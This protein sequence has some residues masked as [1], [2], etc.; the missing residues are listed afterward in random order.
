MVG[1]DILG[2]VMVQTIET[3]LSYS[4]ICRH[5]KFRITMDSDKKY[6]FKWTCTCE[7]ALS[8][9]FCGHIYFLENITPKEEIFNQFL[10][11]VGILR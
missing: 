7:S 11:V 10:Q 9:G 3:D 5:E 4:D 6:V 8:K 2:I 1:V